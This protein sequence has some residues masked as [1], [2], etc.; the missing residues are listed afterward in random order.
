M[1]SYLSRR[2]MVTVLAGTCCLGFAAAVG[3][4]TRAGPTVRADRAKAAIEA[5]HA[6]R[7]QALA[8]AGRIAPFVRRAVS[9]QKQ[10]S[11]CAFICQHRPGPPQPSWLADPG[12]LVYKATNNNDIVTNHVA[13]K[14]TGRRLG[15][16]L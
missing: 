15:V 16:V 12:I 5:T 1:L 3:I 2:A 9:G 4:A 8:S 7:A 13:K 10:T 14:K 11:Y 6:G